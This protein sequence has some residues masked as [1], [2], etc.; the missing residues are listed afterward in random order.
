MIKRSWYYCQFQDCHFG[1]S[2]F[3]QRVEFLFASI[4]YVQ[5]EPFS[6]PVDPPIYRAWNFRQIVVGIGQA[7]RF[8]KGVSETFVISKVIDAFIVLRK[9]DPEDDFKAYLPSIRGRE[10]VDISLGVFPIGQASPVSAGIVRSHDTIVALIVLQENT[11]ASEFPLSFTLCVL[12]TS[13][14]QRSGLQELTP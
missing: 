13:S 14:V 4:K 2:R 12:R 9:S 10:M 1:T 11:F 6:I 8:F 5:I 3:C 7:I